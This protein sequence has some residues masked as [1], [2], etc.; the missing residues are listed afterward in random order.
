MEERGH[1]RFSLLRS[2][3]RPVVVCSTAA[4][5]VN[6]CCSAAKVLLVQ[7]TFFVCIKCAEKTSLF[8]ARWDVSG[9]IMCNSCPWG[10]TFVPSVFCT[11]SCFPL[12]AHGVHGLFPS[13]AVAGTSAWPWLRP[14][15]KK[16]PWLRPVAV[17]TLT[18]QKS[19][20][21]GNDVKTVINVRNGFYR[22]SGLEV[23]YQKTKNAVFMASK[24][25]FGG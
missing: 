22:F 10:D 5:T 19:V 13:A 3:S 15:R 12:Q 24:R 21:N 4:K 2:T 8:S 16:W 23:F 20:F 17:E 9:K 14:R 11:V 1:R 6:F 18:R 7:Q 25:F